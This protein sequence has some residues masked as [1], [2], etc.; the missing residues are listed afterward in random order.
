[1]P[2]AGS[3][4]RGPWSWQGA[5]LGRAL[6]AVAPAMARDG[7]AV[8]LVDGGPEAVAAAALGGV[9]GRL[10]P[11]LGAR[12]RP[13]R[14][15]A[16]DRRAAATRRPD[17]ARRADPRRTSRSTPCPAAPATRT[18]S[19]AGGLFAAPER[20][21]SRPFS[22]A[23]AARTV[24]EVAVETLR[25]RGEP[26]RW[27]R[28]LGE[29]LVGLDRAGQLRRLA[30][31]AADDAPPD[32][33]PDRRA[34]RGAAPVGR[35]RQRPGDRRPAAPRAARADRDR[36][37]D[38]S[39]EATPATARRRRARR[40]DRRRDR[41]VRD[42]VDRL[43]ALIR[44][45]MSRTTQ[46][47]S[48]SSNPAAGGSPIARTATPPPPARGPRRVGRVQP[49]VHRR[50]DVRGRVL[51]PD[52]VAVRRPRPARRGARPGLPRQLPKRDEH[53]R[54]AS[55]PPTICSNA[56]R[57]TRNCSARSP[58]AA[59]GWACGS[60]CRTRRSAVGSGAA[61]SATSS[62]ERE[63]YAYLGGISRST[64][65]LA[66]VDCVWYIRGKLAF[67]FEVEW[68]AMLGEPLLRKHARIAPDERI[69]RFL[70]IPPE[71]TE[72]VRYK[73]ARSPLLRAALE[74]GRGTS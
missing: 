61:S 35:R 1:M 36:R 4:L 24:T 41:P 7:R 11:H 58:T 43:L 13:G 71:R 3:S 30:G 37:A 32:A 27:E 26:A 44:D 20:F 55:R 10:P 16:R 72:L 57:S 70:V 17:A 60:G 47:A 22:A 14:R 31:D 21:E 66:E 34:T 8:Q 23:E 15:R 69:V 6:E 18:S 28:L 65:E 51:R 62:H 49:A 48:S 67:L 39:R 59:I 64:D 68:T 19:T 9:G 45:E 12:R 63:R 56:A 33:A 42:P 5:A 40:R 50:P 2:S 46:T 38:R 54:T 73:L 29:I 53:D 74:E 25:A 52:R